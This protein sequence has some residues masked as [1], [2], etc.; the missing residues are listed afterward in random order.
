MR[1]RV[2]I[3]EVTRGFVDVEADSVEEAE[4]AAYRENANGNTYWMDTDVEIVE[5][6]E[7]D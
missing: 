5:V 1:Y 4:E 3:K 7:N 6:L 2:S